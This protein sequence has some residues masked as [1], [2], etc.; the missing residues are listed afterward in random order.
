MR[1]LEKVLIT[2]LEIIMMNKNLHDHLINSFSR[3]IEELIEIIEKELPYAVNTYYIEKRNGSKRKI[4][5]VKKDSL[6]WQLQRFLTS[7]YF[8][9]FKYPDYVFGYQKNK[10]YIDFLRYHTH[11]T[12]NRCFL[13]LDIKDFFGTINTKSLINELLY[14]LENNEYKRNKLVPLFHLLLTHENKLPQGFQTSP[15][16][17]NFFLR[18]ADLRIQKYSH[19]INFKYS[20]YADDMIFSFSSSNPQLFI[21]RIISMVNQILFDFELNLNKFKTR[22]SKRELVLNG[23]IVG[24]EI[25]L[26]QAKLKELRRILFIIE[27]LSKN[28]STESMLIKINS[29]QNIINFNI[30][31]LLDY[32]SGYRSFLISTIKNTSITSSWYKKASSLIRRIESAI[33]TIY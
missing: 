9:E 12:K 18:R 1:G 26:S 19:K 11:S 20:R 8:S 3:S 10:S 13:K 30:T 6:L 25:R 2:F 28:D 29:G 23:F 4:C 22:F 7:N 5:E 24:S 16:L 33:L 14:S 21:T 15:M 17:S 32:L 31:Y 27:H